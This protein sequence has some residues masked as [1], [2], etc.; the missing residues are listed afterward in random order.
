MG[1]RRSGRGPRGQRPE[2]QRRCPRHRGLR[3]RNTGPR[4]QSSRVLHLSVLRRPRQCVQ[5]SLGDGGHRH[6]ERV[7]RRS[8]RRA[9]RGDGLR[10]PRRSSAGHPRAW[11]CRN[12]A[13]T[14][15]AAS[16]AGETSRVGGRT[17]RRQTA[18]ARA[19]VTGLGRVGAALH[20]DRAASRHAHR[21]AARRREARTKARRRVV[22]AAAL[23]PDAGRHRATPGRRRP[24]GAVVDPRHLVVPAI[25]RRLR[26]RPRLAATRDRLSQGGADR[27]AAAAAVPD[28]TRAPPP[29]ASERAAADEARRR[30]VARVERRRAVAIPP[31]DRT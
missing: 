5:T 27:P 26:L 8:A 24:M 28:R 13:P 14:A 25:R 21:T 12:A 18:G 9:S 19:H 20:P 4:W 3:G 31:G 22:Q 29:G 2:R 10:R 15:R 7:A 17:R 6:R 1:V 11:W 23:A 30:G 16:H